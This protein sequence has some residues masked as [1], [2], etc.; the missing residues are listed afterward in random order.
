MDNILKCIPIKNN[1]RIKKQGEDYVV[2]NLATS[3]FHKV[4]ADVNEVLEKMDENLT[5]EELISYFADAR[6]LERET[7]ANEFVA[8]IKELEIRN[9]ILLEQ[10]NT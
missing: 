5:V 8:F 1:I 2:F 3:G 6:K 9:I 4:T 10:P 7:F